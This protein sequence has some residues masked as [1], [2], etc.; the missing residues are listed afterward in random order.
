[1]TPLFTIRAE[2]FAILCE[3]ALRRQLSARLRRAF[4]QRTASMDD[5]EL[6][7]RIDGAAARSRAFGLRPRHLP[8]F[9]AFEMVFG[10]GA[11]DDPQQAWA[12]EILRSGTFSPDARAQRLREAAILRLAREADEEEWQQRQDALDAAAEP[13]AELH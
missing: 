1:M 2:P 10:E 4:P 8:A 7:R 3:A 11:A 13:A 6:A 9:A 12:G 5:G